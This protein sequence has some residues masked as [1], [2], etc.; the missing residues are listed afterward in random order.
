MTFR[1][2]PKPSI[3]MVSLICLKPGSR[4]LNCSGLACLSCTRTSNCSFKLLISSIKAVATEPIVALSG[5]SS[6]R[7][8][9]ST[10][11]FEGKASSKLNS[12]LVALIKSVS[13]SQRAT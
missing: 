1:G 9:S 7:L 2:V 12:F 3:P 10:T 6:A 11:E 8:S 4:L 13:T 5:P